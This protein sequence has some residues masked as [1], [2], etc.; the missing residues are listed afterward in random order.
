MKKQRRQ[1]NKTNDELLDEPRKLLPNYRLVV[2]QDRLKQPAIPLRW[3][4][5]VGPLR[6]A[7]RISRISRRGLFRK[8]G[9]DTLA[10]SSVFFSQQQEQEISE[11]RRIIPPKRTNPLA[12]RKRKS[13]SR[14]LTV[15]SNSGCNR[16]K[17]LR[18]HLVIRAIDFSK[19]P[20][21]R[22]PRHESHDSYSLRCNLG[23]SVLLLSCSSLERLERVLSLSL[24]LVAYAL[25]QRLLKIRR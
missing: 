12:K 8:R 5:H 6:S 2:A 10:P 22:F 16:P 15:A 21:A 7:R 24:C 3:I 4:I 17:Y 25:R 9:R 19:V 20:G 13:S 18:G 1:T 23:S 11:S 14:R